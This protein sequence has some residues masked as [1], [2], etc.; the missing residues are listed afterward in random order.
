MI[1]Q[2]TNIEL[3]SV[4]FIE[5]WYSAV[6]IGKYSSIQKQRQPPRDLPSYYILRKSKPVAKLA[7]C[8]LRNGKIVFRISF[9]ALNLSINCE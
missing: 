6:S 3:F 4:F 5:S 1:I 2:F 7:K 8:L 9:S